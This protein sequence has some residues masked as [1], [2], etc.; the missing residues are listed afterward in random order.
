MYKTS[1][2]RSDLCHY[3]DAYI[4]TKETIDLLIADENEKDKAQENVALKIMLKN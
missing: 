2:L 3:G 1:M 4:L